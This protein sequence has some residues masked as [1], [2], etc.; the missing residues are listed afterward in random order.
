MY[1]AG[2]EYVVVNET[3]RHG[4]PNE[5]TIVHQFES[6]VETGRTLVE[7]QFDEH[8]VDAKPIAQSEQ[9]RW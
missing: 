3:V 9:H 2:R 1:S 5:P 8:G 4:I 7:R 6:P